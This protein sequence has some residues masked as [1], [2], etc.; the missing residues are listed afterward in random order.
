MFRIHNGHDAL[1]FEISQHFPLSP[2]QP[3]EEY[4]LRVRGSCG[5]LTFDKEFEATRQALLTFYTKLKHC[6]DTLD[7]V[8]DMPSFSYEEDFSI[9]LTFTRTG[10]VHVA[11]AMREND[12]QSISC[13]F[14]FE[15]DQT[16][17]AET[18]R[19]MK[20]AFGF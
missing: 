15:T 9:C 4:F 2:N 16:Y 7:G 14:E 11:A 3:I 20:T 17:L 8:C 5:F 6:Y 18:L 13:R 19:G 12:W 10:Q 1:S